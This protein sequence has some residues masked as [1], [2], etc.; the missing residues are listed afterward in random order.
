MNFK[1]ALILAALLAPLA[2][3][4]QKCKGIQYECANMRKEEG[5]NKSAKGAPAWT[6]TGQSRYGTFAY[7][8]TTEVAISVFKGV[9]YRISFC[10]IDPQIQGKLVFQ[11]VER[12]TQAQTEEYFVTEEVPKTDAQGNMI[13][14]A[15]G[16]PIMETKSIKKTRRVYGKTPIIRYNNV[17]DGNKQWVEFTTDMDRSLIVRVVVP[18]VGEKPK[19]DLS[20]QGFA[21]IGMLVEQQMGPQAGGW[22]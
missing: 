2:S 8:D 12:K 7:G 1:T 22:K 9:N 15:E 17:D 18:S 13:T 20:P 6:V 14:D 21:C 10:S 3:F 19:N 16:N 5:K 4:S 11:I